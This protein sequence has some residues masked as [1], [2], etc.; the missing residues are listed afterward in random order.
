MCAPRLSWRVITCSG[1]HRVHGLPRGRRRQNALRHRHYRIRA[2][3]GLL[4]L[5]VPRHFY[6]T[7]LFARNERP[8]HQRMHA[9]T[10]SLFL[11]SL[12][13]ACAGAG[14]EADAG[15][16]IAF[17]AITFNTGTTEGMS[18]DEPPDDGYG[19]VQ[20]GYSDVYYGDGLAWQAVV[21]DTRAFLEAEEPDVIGFQEMFFSDDCAGI[22]EEAR[23]GFVCETWS[24]GDRTVASIVLGENYR[25]AC[26]LEKSDKCIGVKK[27]F[28]RQCYRF[29]PGFGRA[30]VLGR[31]RWSWLGSVQNRAEKSIAE[32]EFRLPCC[33]GRGCSARMRYRRA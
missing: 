22:P 24:P 4:I 11:F 32:G 5:S 16:P 31:K 2:R 1:S 28:A 8:E 30:H 3:R 9:R 27:A 25:V 6:A 26:H 13:T 21:D 29:G 19:G 10:P 12:C 7:A 14:P 20:A 23:A 15:V 17:K 18:H 33:S